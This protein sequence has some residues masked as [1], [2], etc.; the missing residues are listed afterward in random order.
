[1]SDPSTPEPT[2]LWRMR[3]TLENDVP[4]P[5][6]PEGISVRRFRPE[7]A[8]A[9]H[10]LLENA[11][12]SG[13]G[14]VDQFETWLPAMTSDAEFDPE[15]WFLAEADGG[16]LAGAALCWTS[17]FLKDLVVHESWRRR[18]LGAALVH[19]VLGEFRR[20]DAVA[21]DLKVESENPSGAERLYEQ[22]GFVVVERLRP[23]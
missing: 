10:A 5:A 20:R 21:V 8:P 18:G 12:R 2:E 19:H 4:R 7:D 13:G 23:G 11:Y 9:V 3:R 15:L 14:S 1:V 22:L 6:W 16:S 17:A